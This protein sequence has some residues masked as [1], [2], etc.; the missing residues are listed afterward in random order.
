VE[1]L[2]VVEF[3]LS[4]V[5]T[6]GTGAARVLA[7]RAAT[8]LAWEPVLC[9]AQ[10][11][12]AGPEQAA[13]WRALAGYQEDRHLRRVMLELSAYCDGGEILS[14]D[15]AQRTAEDLR[16]A[17]LAVDAENRGDFAE[18]LRL[19]ETS[20]RPL[21]EPWRCELERVMSYGEQMT[22]AQ[23]GRWI[24]AAALRW[25]QSTTRGL[26]LGVHYATVALRALGA[27]EELLWGQAP[28]GPPGQGICTCCHTALSRGTLCS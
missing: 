19:L 28:V 23:W 2:A 20:R 1:H 11:L 6:A 17:A 18:A 14:G 21:D 24:C 15:E 4:M 3:A 27:S 13:N 26:E 8:A 10:A 9:G 16:L 5:C 22:P 12:Y 25:C 7:E